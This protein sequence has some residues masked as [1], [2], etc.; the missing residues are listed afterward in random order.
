MEGDLDPGYAEI[1]GLA[2]CVRAIATSPVRAQTTGLDATPGRNAAGADP[3]EE[4]RIG[5]SHLRRAPWETCR[6]DCWGRLREDCEPWRNRDLAHE[7]PCYT[8][9][10]DRP[11]LKVH[12]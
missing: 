12:H 10:P 5:R 8:C 9:S 1:S 4:R 6:F 2:C 7:V 3:R 11:T